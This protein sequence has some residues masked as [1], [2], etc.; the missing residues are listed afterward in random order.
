M[1][2]W[3]N[4]GLQ[5]LSQSSVA[6]GLAALL[7]LAGS[8]GAYFL[9]YRPP[10]KRLEVALA[11]LA[12][13]LAASTDG[14]PAAKAQAGLLTK[15]HPAL[16]LAWRETED[17]VIPLPFG[18][19][20]IH[21]MFGAPRDIWNAKHL[22]SQQMNLALAE[23]VPNLLVGLGLL[24][25]F[26]FLTLALT[27]ATSALVGLPAQGQADLLQATRGL[28]SAAGA[29][30]MT[31]MAGLLASIVWA[32][33]S[34][35]QVATLNRLSGTILEHLSKLVPGGGGEMAALAQLQTSRDHLQTSRDVGAQHT[36]ATTELLGLTQELLIESREKTGTLKRFETDL[37]VSL[38][39]AISQ[40]VSPQVAT[41][42]SRL[43]GAI[44]GLSS[45]IGTMNQQAMQQ[46]L[47]DFSAMLKQQ[48]DEEM[49]Q[50]R[51][52]LE[53]LSGKLDNA[54]NTIGKSATEASQALDKAGA[55]L[56]GRVKEVSDNSCEPATDR[57]YREAPS[58]GISPCQSG[59]IPHPDKERAA[60][61][62]VCVLGFRRA[63]SSFGAPRLGSAVLAP[64]ASLGDEKWRKAHK[65]MAIPLVPHLLRRF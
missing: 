20:Q 61:A 64:G 30:F 45:K 5:F 48:T 40:A 50:L 31:S 33:A 1:E 55:E 62:S 3:L 41:M 47:T 17:R 58:S 60:Q 38:A 39:N 56:L 43:I 21:V 13:E 32:I 23:A 10:A 26:F 27:Q 53:G 34:R 2:D 46:M 15:K 11:G 52:T 9:W 35:R 4:F 12:T 16:A 49:S 36:E 44:D 7:I 22:L 37:A 19:R 29:K 14:W 24:F 65:A 63:R 51:Q 8:I 57:G 59:S 25:T 42:T 54:G 18:E 28:L 6:V